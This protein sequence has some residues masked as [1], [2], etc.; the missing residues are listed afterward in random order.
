MDINVDLTKVVPASEMSGEDDEETKLLQEMLVEAKSYLKS[1]KW[2]DDLKSSFFGLGVGGIV[3]VFLFEIEHS[4][5]V[6]DDWVWIIVGDIPSA[7]ITCED[8]PNPACALDGYIGAMREWANAAMHG[9]SVDDLIPVNVPA[10]PDWG[11][12]LRSRLEFMEREILSQ[13]E[14][15]LRC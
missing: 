11:R 6:V 1:F 4:R 15:D 8:A 12:E 13:Y 10:T 3:A 14:D 5:P 2:C 9:N 7:Y